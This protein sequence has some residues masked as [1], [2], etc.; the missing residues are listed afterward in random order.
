[1]MKANLRE[2]EGAVDAKGEEAAFA[3]D[4]RVAS[5]AAAAA[6]ILY[7]ASLIRAVPPCPS[8]VRV[9]WWPLL[10]GHACLVSSA[11]V[12]IRLES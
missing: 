3:A 7:T 12:W 6:R 1:M 5:A 4:K 11:R 9:P 8:L 2:D 10:S